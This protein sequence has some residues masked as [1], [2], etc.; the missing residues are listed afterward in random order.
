MKDKNYWLLKLMPMF[1][2]V[3]SLGTFLGTTQTASGNAAT[4]TVRDPVTLVISVNG[5]E[6]S[7][8]VYPEAPNSPVVMCF[9]GFASTSEM[10]D[11][12]TGFAE[13]GDALW[14][15]GQQSIR[16]KPS[17]G[18]TGCIYTLAVNSIL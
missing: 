11:Q 9:H 17:V 10:F 14:S 8:L 5:V 6:R 16:E 13:L 1:S 3:V 12:Y 2:V 18:V 15:C 7:A 4:T